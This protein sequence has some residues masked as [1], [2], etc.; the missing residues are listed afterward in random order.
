MSPSDQDAVLSGPLAYCVSAEAIPDW[1]QKGK[2]ELTDASGEAWGSVSTMQTD[3]SNLINK[4]VQDSGATWGGAAGD[5]M[6]T[7]TSPLSTWADFTS[8]NAKTGASAVTE[9]G[10]AFR[11]AQNSVQPAVNVP[12][13]PW[14]NDGVPW[15]TDYDDAVEKKQGVNEQNMRVINTYADRTNYSVSNMPM[16]DAPEGSTA[17]VDDG[18]KAIIEPIRTWPPDPPPEVGGGGDDKN[19]IDIGGGVGGK[20][21]VNPPVLPPDIGVD[22]TKPS[23]VDDGTG[24]TKP[25]DIDGKPIGPPTPGRPPI[26]PPVGIDPP[27]VIPPFGPN[28]PRNPANRPGVGR[29]GGGGGGGTGRGGG[30]TG[31]AGG[32][33]GG[34][35]MGGVGTGAGRGGMG[36]FGPGGAAAAGAFGPGGAAGQLGE[37][38][39]RAG[40]AAAGGGFGPGGAGAAG[41]RGAGGAGGMAGGAGGAKGEGGDDLEHTSKYLQPSDEYFGDGTMVAP[42]VIG[43]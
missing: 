12:D 19:K 42:P 24:T 40:G 26:G 34:R 17:E 18:G 41:G 1:F 36:G 8:E 21:K 39:G 35:G 29:G 32:T 9:I 33:G 5:A 31:G 14:Y 37:S 20:D 30:G 23:N 4:A 38:A 22:T 7:S 25:S 6:R 28:D 16:F 43:G 11:A 2:P 15:D 10:S 27:N 13:K 3:I